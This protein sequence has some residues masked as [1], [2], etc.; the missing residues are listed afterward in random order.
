MC[1]HLSSVISSIWLVATSYDGVASSCL[2]YKDNGHTV[3]GVL[4][5]KPD[6]GAAFDV[7]CDMDT[8]GGGWAVFQR[9]YD[10][11]EVRKLET[12]I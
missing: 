5:I 1:W 2:V 12:G 9:R 4:Q 6:S 8:D 3:S 11:S 10:G 7:Y